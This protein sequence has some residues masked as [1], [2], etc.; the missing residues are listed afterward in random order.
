MKEVTAREKEIYSDDYTFKW[1]EIKQP[2]TTFIYI[3]TPAPFYDYYSFWGYKIKVKNAGGV[4][5]L[6]IVLGIVIPLII[7]IIIIIIVCVVKKRRQY[8]LYRFQRISP[9]PQQVYIQPKTPQL[10]YP[11]QNYIVYQNPPQQNILQPN[12]PQVNY[13]S[14]NVQPNIPQQQQNYQGQN[15]QLYQNQ[16]QQNYLQNQ[17]Y[18]QPNIIPDST[19]NSRDNQKPKVPDSNYTSTPQKQISAYPHPFD[20]QIDSKSVIAG[21][22]NAA[23]VMYKP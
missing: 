16:Q 23:P 8:N 1:D 14:I 9:Q 7:I 6:P 5:V 10:V 2:G 3:K 12:V 4:N 21:K 19:Y 22:D 13:Q 20:A 11:Q 18:Q 15:Y 17:N